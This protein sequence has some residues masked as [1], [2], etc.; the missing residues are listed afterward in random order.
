MKRLSST[1]PSERCSRPTLTASMSGP[2][3]TD[4]KSDLSSIAWQ[5][6]AIV[7]VGWAAGFI[8]RARRTPDAHPPVRRGGQAKRSRPTSPSIIHKLG[9][10]GGGLPAQSAS[11]SLSGTDSAAV[12]WGRPTRRGR[13]FTILRDGRGIG[14]G[15]VADAV[16]R[17]P[18]AGRFAR[19]CRAA[20][21]SRAPVRSW[22][23]QRRPG[24]SQRRPGMPLKI[25]LPEH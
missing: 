12:R 21:C 8:V 3:R 7:A 16:D 4:L 15:R 22:P 24:Q 10:K 18:Q 11:D 20:H 17:E 13:K 1:L 25:G 19:N 9:R 6:S 23:F 2:L 5:S 14:H